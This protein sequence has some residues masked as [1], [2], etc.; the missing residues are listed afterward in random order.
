MTSTRPVGLFTRPNEA[1]FV[2]QD[3][4]PFC[5]DADE[6]ASDAVP[7]DFHAGKV[8]DLIG[9]YGAERIP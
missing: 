5:R 3:C 4:V 9:D 6:G 2:V 7:D 8:F 1:R